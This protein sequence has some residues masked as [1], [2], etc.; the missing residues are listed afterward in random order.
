MAAV[1][2]RA[3]ITIA[4]RRYNTKEGASLTFGGVTREPVIGD[5]GVAGYQG[6]IEA[7]KVDCTIIHV[8]DVSLK[9]IQSVS[10][11]TISFDTD[12][13]KSYIISNGFCG[14]AL[15]VSKDGIKATF[16]GTNCEEA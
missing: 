5:G 1:F 14:Q 12:N 11:A 7:P 9:T 16:F 8:P 2:G 10:D 3:Y 13:G 4:G 6:K 15:E